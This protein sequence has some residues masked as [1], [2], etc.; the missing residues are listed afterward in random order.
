MRR[1][2][3]AREGS[4]LTSGADNMTANTRLPVDLT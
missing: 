3:V 1:D 4:Q 2:D